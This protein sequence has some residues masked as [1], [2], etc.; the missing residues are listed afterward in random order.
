MGALHQ[1]EPSFWKTAN[2]RRLQALLDAFFRPEG[3]SERSHSL[4]TGE[5]RSLSE[6]LM[7]GGT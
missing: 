4:Q 3:R 2:P 1:D 5:K 6:Y 7:G